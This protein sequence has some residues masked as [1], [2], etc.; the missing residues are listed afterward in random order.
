MVRRIEWFVAA[1]ALV[2]FP[3]RA[4]TTAVEIRGFAFSPAAVGIAT[5][6]AASWTNFDGVG[7]TVT[8]DTGAFSSGTLGRNSTYSLFFL[9]PG[10]FAYHCAIH[11]TM[12]GS[13]TV[14][15]S[16]TTPPAPQLTASPGSAVGD[17]RL[18]WTLNA[19]GVT[20]YEVSRDGSPIATTTATTYVDHDLT[21][22]TSHRYIV[23]ASSAAGMGPPSNEACTKP[24]PWIAAL[25]C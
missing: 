17:I 25:G 9:S 11:P 22:L 4:A 24:F 15:G 21:P 6:D 12:R 18:S 14:T 16:A 23:R 19:L 2:A 10:T 5:G 20:S 8:S 7:H 13:V 3:A 1:R